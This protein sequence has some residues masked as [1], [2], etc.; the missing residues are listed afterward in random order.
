MIIGAGR[1]FGTKITAKITNMSEFTFIRGL[2]FF[3]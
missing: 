2:I 3:P 1:T